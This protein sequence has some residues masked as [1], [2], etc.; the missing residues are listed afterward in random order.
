MADIDL[1]Y[2]VAA[3]QAAPVFLD[4]NA[5]VGKAIGLI[6]EAARGGARLIGFPETWVPGYPWWIWL[7]SPAWGMQFVQRYHANSLIVDSPQTERI[8]NAAKDND[9]NVVLGYSEKAGGSLYIGQMFVRRNGSIVT[10]RRKLKPTHVERTV[11][12]ESDGSHL[13]VQEFDDLGK[14]G[15]LCCWEH[16]QPLTKYAMYSMGE[17]VHVASWGHGT[18][19][20][21]LYA[22]TRERCR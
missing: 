8:Q 21:I 14:V 6:E 13:S 1:R 15:A 20:G 7:G 9:I 5:T 17:Q 2:K 3:V 11:F 18:I 16:L 10:T 12:G 4:L 22:K 19:L